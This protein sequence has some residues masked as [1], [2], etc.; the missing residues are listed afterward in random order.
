MKLALTIFGLLIGLWVLLDAI[1]G[2]ATVRKLW[3]GFQPGTPPGGTAERA[4]QGVVGGIF[5]LLAV[6][7]LAAGHVL[8]AR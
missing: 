3:I 4:G 6:L 7:L 8:G 5:I 1:F 2:W